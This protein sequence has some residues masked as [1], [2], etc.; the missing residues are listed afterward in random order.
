MEMGRKCLNYLLL[1][2]LIIFASL[3]VCASGNNDEDSWMDP[4]A[5]T[6]DYHGSNSLQSTLGKCCKCSE[7]AATS[8]KDEK[9]DAGL[10][11]STE[12]VATLIYFKKF[13]TM[14]FNR[15]YLKVSKF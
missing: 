15:K 1:L 4:D 13:I 12:E 6:R 10:Q 14:L 2:L 5:W 11:K 3:I 8:D 9:S 7:D